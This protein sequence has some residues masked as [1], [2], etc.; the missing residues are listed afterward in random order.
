MCRLFLPKLRRACP[1]EVCS[2]ARAARGWADLAAAAV[3]PRQRIAGHPGAAFVSLR[4][5]RIRREQ[6]ASLD[7]G[8]GLRWPQW[9]LPCASWILVGVV[10]DSLL[11]RARGVRAPLHGALAKTQGCG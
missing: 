3:T 9:C 1:R 4:L 5:V 10:R 8:S 2:P 7:T 11:S 6:E